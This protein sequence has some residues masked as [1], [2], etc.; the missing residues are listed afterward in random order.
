MASYAINLNNFVSRKAQTVYIN[1]LAG[2]GKPWHNCAFPNKC[3]NKY[4]CKCS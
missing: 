4:I 2:A 1:K 3:N